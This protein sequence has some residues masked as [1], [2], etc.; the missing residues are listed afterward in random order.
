MSVEPASVDERAHWEARYAAREGDAGQAPSEWVIQ[1]C[2]AL[3]ADALILDVAGGVGRH[4]APLARSG[5]TV[6]VADF[7]LRAVQRA[8]ATHT[9]VLGVVADASS[10]PFRAASLGAVVGVNFLDRSIF[11]SLAAVLSPGGALV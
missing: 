6:V 9:S 3:P 7:I 4:A 1:Q 8:R 2:L 11:P 5:R 10:L